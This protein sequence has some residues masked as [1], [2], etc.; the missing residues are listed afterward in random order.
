VKFNLAEMK[1]LKHINNGG[2]NYG[3]VF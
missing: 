2:F 1:E 3:I